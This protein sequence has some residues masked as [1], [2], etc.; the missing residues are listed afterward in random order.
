MVGRLVGR[1]LGVVHQ[2]VVLVQK[3]EVLQLEVHQLVVLVQREEG[4]QL[5]A[6]V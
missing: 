4:L 3:E 6:L 2:L 5:E 1:L